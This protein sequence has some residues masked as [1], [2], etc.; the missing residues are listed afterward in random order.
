MLKAVRLDMNTKR[1]YKRKKTL[2]TEYTNSV[3]SKFY[4][5]TNGTYTTDYLLNT[6]YQNPYS[7]WKIENG[8]FLFK[9]PCHDS[10]NESSHER[11][12]HM[13]HHILMALLERELLKD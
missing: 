11:T 12:E 10:F 9:H 7:K 3:D 8:V 13:V 6:Q 1:K 5:Y 4:F 2:L